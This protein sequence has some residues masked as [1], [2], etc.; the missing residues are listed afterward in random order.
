MTKNFRLK[1]S[2]GVHSKNTRWG[3]GLLCLFALFVLFVLCSGWRGS[4]GGGLL[5]SIVKHSDTT[6]TEAKKSPLFAFIVVRWY[7]IPLQPIKPF[8]CPQIEPHGKNRKTM[9]EERKKNPA[10]RRGKFYYLLANLLA[11]LYTRA[12]AYLRASASRSKR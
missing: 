4:S 2:I 3:S 7:I 5:P 12:E 1:I 9:N 6:N 8:I 10:R 11:H